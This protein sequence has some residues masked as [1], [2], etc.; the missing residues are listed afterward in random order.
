MHKTNKIVFK[1]TGFIV[2]AHLSFEADR[3]LFM[4]DK[5]LQMMFAFK[6][7]LRATL[8]DDTVVHTESKAQQC[9]VDLEE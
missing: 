6:F 3:D 7:V 4:S 2:V 9:A 8:K 5:A 1:V